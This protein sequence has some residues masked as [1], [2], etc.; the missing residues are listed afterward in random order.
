MKQLT[1]VMNRLH[2]PDL[3]LLLL[4]VGVGAVFLYHGWDKV[5]NMEGV[6]GFFGSLGFPPALAYLVA[7][8]ETLG[9][10]ALILGVYAR[11]AALLTAIVALVALVK[12]H[13]PNGFSI[14]AGGYE[15]ILV[16]L[17]GSLAV[18][19]VGAGRY[20]LYRN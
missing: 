20:V 15:F 17:V 6:I 10:I 5:G 4:R 9:G 16:L 8:I 11:H 7:W 18:L 2:N 3:G 13:L 12:V 1:S 19:M 14:S